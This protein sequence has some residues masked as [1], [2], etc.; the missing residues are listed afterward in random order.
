MSSHIKLA[1]FDVRDKQK[2]IKNQQIE[3]KLSYL[4]KQDKYSG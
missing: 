1:E 4:K 2:F 3:L